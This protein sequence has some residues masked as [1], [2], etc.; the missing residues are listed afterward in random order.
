MIIGLTGSICCGK[1]TVSKTFIHNNIP[2]VDGDVITAQV[3][4][5]GQPA[6]SEII[7][8]FGS[9][10]LTEG[11]FLN[12]STFGNL[13]FHNPNE[14]AKL[15]KIIHPYLQQE[16]TSQLIQ[17]QKTY[18]LAVFDAALII[19]HNHADRYRPLIVVHC[20]YETQL[21]RLMK[22]NNLTKLDAEVRIA[23]QF[24]SEQKLKFADYSIDT[25]E[26]IANSIKQTE[27]IIEDIK[28]KFL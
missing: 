26:S 11:G 17:M 1:S 5:P 8:V 14:M 4:E 15:N 25:S 12:R 9:Q 10:Y 21:K 27:D 18:P 2:V 6:L 13:V 23:A 7:K 20:P 16:I 3:L 24:S 22:R 19:E 28:N